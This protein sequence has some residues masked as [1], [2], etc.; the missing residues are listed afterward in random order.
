MFRLILDIKS[1]GLSRPVDVVS[2]FVC[3][4]PTQGNGLAEVLLLILI[5]RVL[6]FYEGS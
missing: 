3:V 1:S 6:P 4:R 5:K 2:L